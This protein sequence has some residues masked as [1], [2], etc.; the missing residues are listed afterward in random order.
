MGEYADMMLE[1]VCCAGC[2]EF[3]DNEDVPGYACYCPSCQPDFDKP[4]NE[5]GFL[6]P[7][8]CPDCGKGFK[9]AK[10]AEQHYRDKHTPPPDPCGICGKRLKTR[11]SLQQHCMDKHGMTQREAQSSLSDP[12]R[13]ALG[14]A[15]V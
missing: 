7:H 4:H 15:V 12:A 11:Q 13:A 6:K 1:G 2:G 14:K 3:L 8:T 5:W 10:G 9:T